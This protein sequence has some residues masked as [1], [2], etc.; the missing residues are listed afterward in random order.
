MLNEQMK[1]AHVSSEIGD[2][3]FMGYQDQAGF[4]V[5]LDTDDNVLATHK[6]LAILRHCSEMVRAQ[7]DNRLR[8]VSPRRKPQTKFIVN[9]LMHLGVSCGQIELLS[10]SE[11]S[12][13]DGIWLLVN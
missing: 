9:T 7:P 4:K 1:N 3:E 12:Q 10:R 2:T 13:A 8:I 11:Q 5:C 6:E